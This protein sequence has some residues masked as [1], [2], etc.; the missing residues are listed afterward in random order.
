MKTR[1]QFQV[2]EIEALRRIAEKTRR[3]RK[4]NENISGTRRVD[5]IGVW[6]EGRKVEL[7]LHIDTRRITEA[8]LIRIGRDSKPIR[9]SRVE[10]PRK[11]WED[12]LHLVN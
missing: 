1:E 3:D 7:N 11:R 4:T 12:S 10:R 6:T 5:N 8:K 2:S 9:S